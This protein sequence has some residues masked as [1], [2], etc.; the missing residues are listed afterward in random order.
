M[1]KP[2]EHS[3]ATN[4]SWV[5]IPALTPYV[6]WVCCWFSPLP[7]MVFSGY[8]GFP[9]SSKTNISKFQ[10]DQESGRQR[11]T[12]WM[13]YLQIVISLFTKRI[14]HHFCFQDEFPVGKV[15]HF[16]LMA[17]T[18]VRFEEYPNKSG[19][20]TFLSSLMSCV[21]TVFS[22][23]GWRKTR[24]KNG[25]HSFVSQVISVFYLFYLLF[26][27][28]QWITSRIKTIIN[29]LINNKSKICTLLGRSDCGGEISEKP[30]VRY[31]G[32]I[33]SDP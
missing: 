33:L 30:K 18:S 1:A 26:C 31:L 28:T 14:S 8:S 32:C 5:Q 19:I 2:R 7:R 22:V 24:F 21:I 12:M 15:C 3:P 27:H 6:G 11:T 29:R 25:I 10:F 16:F 23:T 9:L 13:C 20:P 4:V 17:S